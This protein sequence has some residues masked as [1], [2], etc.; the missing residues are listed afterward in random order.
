MKCETCRLSPTTISQGSELPIDIFY[1]C[2]ACEDGTSPDGSF[3]K[4]EKSFYEKGILKQKY[5][6]SLDADGQ[7]TPQVS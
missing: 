6:Q 5:N 4:S 1:K 7:K 3:W 2:R